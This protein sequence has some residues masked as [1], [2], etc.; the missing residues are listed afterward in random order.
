MSEFRLQCP[1]I[2]TDSDVVVP[3]HGGGGRMTQKL[4]DTVFLPAFGNP[5]LDQRHD[6]ANL[7]SS[8]RIA[9]TTD[10]FVVTPWRFPGGNIGSLSIHGTV[11]DLAMAGARPIAL[12]AGFVLEEGFPLAC[13]NEVVQAMAS[14]AKD[15]GVPIVAG[16]TKVVE[17]GRGD[18]VYINTTGIGEVIAQAPISPAEVKPGDKVIVSGDLGRHGAAVMTCREGLQ[19]DSEILSD[20][21]SVVSSALALIEAGI[22]VRCLRDST[23]GGLASVLNEIASA[24]GVEICLDESAVPLSEEVAG[25]CEL[26]GLDPLYV[27]CEGRYA[28]FVAAEDGERAA[29][30]MRSHPVSS[31]ACIVGVVRTGRPGVILK[32]SLGVDRVLDLLSGEQLPRIC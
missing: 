29:A 17:R 32:T 3:A 2:F 26:L 30:I 10:T 7:A 11:N 22:Q 28:A 9:V 14:A 19:L 27:A 1:V 23:R 15:A 13:L 4:L 5:A 16:D 31:K 21:A 24:S 18:G 6:A 8:G 20:S 12:T 25:V